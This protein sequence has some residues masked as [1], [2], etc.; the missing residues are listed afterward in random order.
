[1]VFFGPNGGLYR[2][3]SAGGE[4]GC[5]FRRGGLWALGLAGGGGRGGVESFFAAE[6]IALDA[7]L[8]QLLISKLRATSSSFSS[9]S[10]SSSADCSL[11]LS[12]DFGCA[13]DVA[14]LFSLA[15]DVDES[16]K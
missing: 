10:S 7:S 2:S 8:S 1:L 12:L 14:A 15:S 9:P 16:T 11:S 6:N 13:S 3:S 5:S 4:G